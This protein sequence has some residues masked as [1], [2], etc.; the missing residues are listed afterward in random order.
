ML[1][2]LGAFGVGQS[3]WGPTIYGLF[4]VRDL[5]KVKEKIIDRLYSNVDIINSYA[6]NYGREIKKYD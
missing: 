5:I 2:G 1:K 6:N 4:Y 3:S